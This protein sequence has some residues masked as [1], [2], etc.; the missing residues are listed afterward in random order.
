LYEVVDFNLSDI[1][2]PRFPFIDGRKAGRAEVSTSMIGNKERRDAQNLTE[3]KVIADHLSDFTRD[4]RMLRIALMA[5]P[6]GAIGTVVSY[7]LLWLIGAITNLCFYQRLSPSLISPSENHLGL[8]VVA[9]PVVGGLIVGA[10]ARYGSEKIRGHGIPEAL[11]AILIGRSRIESKVAVLKAA[12]LGDFYRHR[13][14]LWRGRTH[15]HDRR[16]IRLAVRA[17]VSSVAG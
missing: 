7:A 10:M 4:H 13:R 9:V 8:W 3:I 2:F 17:V 11:E 15:H 12:L 1:Y 6:I 5:V 14:S 16:R